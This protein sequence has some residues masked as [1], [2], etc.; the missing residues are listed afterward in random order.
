[1]MFEFLLTFEVGLVK[2]L[3]DEA[4]ASMVAFPVRSLVSESANLAFETT[5]RTFQVDSKQ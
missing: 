3:Y 1:M 2:Y 4:L 5:S